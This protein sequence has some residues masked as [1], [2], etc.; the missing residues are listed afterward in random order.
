[1]LGTVIQNVV[2]NLVGDGEYVVFHT[3]VA[4]QFEL[5]PAEYLPRGI[6]RRIEDDCLGV[7]LKS[8]AQFL[9]VESPLASR[10][11]RRTQTDE[12]R[13]RSAD[14][15]VRPIV[16]IEG[17]ED[18]DFVALVTDGQQ[19]GDNGFRRTA[20]DHDFSFR[21]DRQATPLLH[22]PGDGIAQ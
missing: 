21:I 12:A 6:V 18:D 10:T 22:L 7:M 16:L 15:R 3:K 13:L 9:C 19:G 20:T 5:F 1:M 11:L 8:L 14:D 4:D 2:V 17:L